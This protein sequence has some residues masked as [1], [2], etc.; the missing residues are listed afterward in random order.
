MLNIFIG[1]SCHYKVYL[2]YLCFHFLIKLYYWKNHHIS[3]GVWMVLYFSIH[4]FFLR[5][6]SLRFGCFKDISVFLWSTSLPLQCHN[7]YSFICIYFVKV[8]NNFIIIFF[9]VFTRPT[10]LLV[11]RV[12]LWPHF[13]TSILL[14]PH[15][16][17]FYTLFYVLFLF[18]DMPSRTLF[19][20]SPF[21]EF[22]FHMFLISC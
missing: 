5:Y 12:L 21:N 1:L 6:P 20:L 9:D 11:L 4:S 13:C 8:L 17:I 3:A 14:R 7:V 2:F 10:Q 22:Y 19:V 15:T 18:F 16:Y